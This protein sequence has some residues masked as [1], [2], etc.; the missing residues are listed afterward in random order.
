VTDGLEKLRQDLDILEAMA[1]EMDSYLMSEV[2]FWPMAKGGMPRLTL[3]GYLMRQHRLLALKGLLTEDEAARLDAAVSTFNAALVEKVV[4]LEGRAQQEL[5]ARL[6]QWGEYL[7]D[8]SRDSGSGGSYYETAVEPRAMIS[9][10]VNKLKLPPYKLEPRINQ[11]ITMYDNNLRRRWDSGQFVW[12][13]EWQPA[14]PEK[15]YWWLYG[16]PK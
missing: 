11:Q 9:A 5:E 3:G 6:R 12:P 4:R 16:R 10:L 13:E 14:Y 1:G 8:L 7:K 15:S 2:L